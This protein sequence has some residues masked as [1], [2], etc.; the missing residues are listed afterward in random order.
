VRRSTEAERTEFRSLAQ[1]V[2]E[3]HSAAVNRAMTRMPALRGAQV[4]AARTDLVAVHIH[5]SGGH[6][7]LDHRKPDGAGIPA[8]YTACLASGLC[9]LP[10]YRGVAVRGGLPADGDLERFVPG[11]LLRDPEPVSALPIG[12]A[13]DRSAAVG[14]YVIWS[15][16]GRRVRP[17]LGAGPGSASDEV[18]FPPGTG[19]RVLDVRSAGPAPIVLLSE[20]RGAGPGTGDLLGV[21]DDADRVTL[22]RLDEA[23]SR[24]V[25]SPG[26]TAPATWPARCAES[27]GEETGRQ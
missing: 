17:L 11:T 13:A 20:V 25:P 2:W 24:Q 18:V 16:T 8:C 4:D 15:F 21:L 23:L 22:G 9:R 10:S 1:P 7:E 12:V 6:G 26:G 19:F 27:L 14:G 3:R 5:L